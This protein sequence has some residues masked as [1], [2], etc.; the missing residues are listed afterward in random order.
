MGCTAYTT[1]LEQFKLATFNIDLKSTR[2]CA[3]NIRLST[4][5]SFGKFILVAYVALRM[6]QRARAASAVHQSMTW[7]HIIII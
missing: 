1:F 7:L 3:F 2:Y 4:L 5:F 6:C